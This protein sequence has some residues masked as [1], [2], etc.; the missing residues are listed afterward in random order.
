MI[1]RILWIAL[2]TIHAIIMVVTCCYYYSFTLCLIVDTPRFFLNLYHISISYAPVLRVEIVQLQ[3]PPKFF[4]CFWVVRVENRS[5]T[6]EPSLRWIPMCGWIK[7]LASEHEETWNQPFL[8]HS[9]WEDGRNLVDD[10]QGIDSLDGARG[11]DNVAVCC[12]G[13]A[14]F[15]TLVQCWLHNWRVF[16]RNVSSFPNNVCLL[17]WPGS[18]ECGSLAMSRRGWAGRNAAMEPCSCAQHKGSTGFRQHGLWASLLSWF[19]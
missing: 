4:A 13:F 16:C 15:T 14:I 2:V 17:C 5:Q 10:A 19:D 1:P 8:T 7:N 12:N 6:L 18:E 9:P 11:L 3:Q